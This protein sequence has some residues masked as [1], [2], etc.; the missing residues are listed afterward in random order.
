MPK[1]LV[2]QIALALGLLVVLLAAHQTATAV[3]DTPEADPVWGSATQLSSTGQDPRRP[4]I[5]TSP[6]GSHL[7][8]VYVNESDDDPYYTMS[9]NQGQTWSSTVGAK[10]HTSVDASAQVIGAIDQNDKAFAIW[11]KKITPQQNLLVF[12]SK[13]GSANWTAPVTIANSYEIT[14]PS[15]FLDQNNKLHLVWVQEQPAIV[16]YAY[17]ASGT[18]TWSTPV[19]LEEEPLGDSGEPAVAVDRNG[20]LYL[21]WQNDTA[22][23][24]QEI[25]FSRGTLTGPL[26]AP[27]WNPEIEN[28]LLSPA[29]VDIAAHVVM[30]LSGSQL[31]I[32]YTRKVV[33]EDANDKQDVFYAT[34]STPC[35]ALNSDNFSSVSG[36][37]VEVNG[38]D[39]SEVVAALAV[40]SE[41]SA[42]YMTFSGIVPTTLNP[43]EVIQSMQSCDGWGNGTLPH[44]IEYNLDYR[45]IKPAM[46]ASQGWIQLVYDRIDSVSTHEI[47]HRRAAVTCKAILLLPVIRK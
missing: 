38:A 45:F 29:D 44:T 4:R 43:N 21:A 15:V 6:D 20:R 13:T 3:P 8:V 36:G 32:A 17:L 46:A 31:H 7:L 26:A 47:F 16:Y 2:W 40:D 22:S 1:L 37:F 14:D 39:P 23:G 30:A 5:A 19:S 12:S 9:T 27:V 42:A 35:D 18:A 10:I 41:R 28:T 33:V 24:G 34:C 11:V 25:V